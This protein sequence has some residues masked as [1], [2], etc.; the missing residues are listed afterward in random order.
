[1]IAV[2]LRSYRS[3]PTDDF[4]AKN[5]W[6]PAFHAWWRENPN[7]NPVGVENSQ[8]NGKERVEKLGSLFMPKQDSGADDST[9]DHD[10]KFNSKDDDTQL[11]KGDL[12]ANSALEDDSLDVS[13]VIKNN[14]DSDDDSD[15]NLRDFI[16]TDQSE[17]EKARIRKMLARSIP[18]GA[19]L[20]PSSTRNHYFPPHEAP[21][22]HPCQVFPDL[23]P[24]RRS[25]RLKLC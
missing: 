16:K 21:R 13:V 20:P 22:K 17:D 24:P 11:I 2:G 4:S 15:E 1:M 19:H 7:Y 9:E 14:N 18:F 23:A 12:T 3:D 8:G 10:L 25:A 5:I 6:Y